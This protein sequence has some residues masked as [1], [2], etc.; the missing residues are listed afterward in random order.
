MASDP[1]HLTRLDNDDTAFNTW[2]VAWVAHQVVREPLALFDAPIFYPARNALAFSEHMLVQSLMGLPLQWMTGSPVLVYN[3][4]VWLGYTLSGFAMAL[5]MRR[6][7]G[8][9]GAGIVSGCL[10]A[11]NAHLLTRYAHLQALHL[12]FFPVALYAF[13]RV[14]RG[15]G[16]KHAL[17][18]AAM[19]AVQAL[20]SNYTMVLMTAALGVAFIVRREP[21]RL[22]R[23]LWLNMALAGVVAGVMCGFAR[24]GPR[25]H[26][27]QCGKERE[28]P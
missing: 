11:F 18:L 1:A 22:D 13:D 23:R 27:G 17:L 21:Y 3:V 9:P 20:C 25:V 4:L 28:Q 14:L 12:E 6:W 2:V 19:F 10:Y 5:L 24:H 7:T 26:R 8:S 16:S 15:A